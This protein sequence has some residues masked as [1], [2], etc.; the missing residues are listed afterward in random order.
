M[1]LTSGMPLLP[2]Q[3]ENMEAGF[4]LHFSFWLGVLEGEILSGC[5][6][7]VFLWIK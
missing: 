5:L 1:R 4:E 6:G 3:M 2:L 7:I